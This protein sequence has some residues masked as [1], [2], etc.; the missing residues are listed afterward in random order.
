M[1]FLS[2]R[3]LAESLCTI[4]K[5][6]QICA[7]HNKAGR[8]LSLLGLDLQRSTER[9]KFLGAFLKK[10]RLTGSAGGGLMVFPRYL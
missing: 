4:V 7:A 9:V 2:A 3:H 10:V 8:S 5:V 1:V 6:C